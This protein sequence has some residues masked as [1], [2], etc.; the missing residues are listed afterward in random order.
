[1]LDK[2]KGLLEEG[3]I[4]CH[5][6][7]KVHTCMKRVIAVDPSCSYKEVQ[8]NSNSSEIFREYAAYMEIKHLSHKC[9]WQLRVGQPLLWLSSRIFFQMDVYL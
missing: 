2:K 8:E 6:I 9:V 4:A 1:M 3:T 7:M 5:L